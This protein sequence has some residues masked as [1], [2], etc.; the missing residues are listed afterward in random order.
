ML[1]LYSTCTDGL[2]HCGES[3]CA[4]AVM[5][6]NNQIYRE[7]LSR[8]GRTC[9][10][11]ANSCPDEPKMKGCGCPDGL[12]LNDKVISYAAQ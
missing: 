11:S 2:L 5:C 6:P 9:L 10:D 1:S 4:L 7:D 12:L 3:Q 8:C